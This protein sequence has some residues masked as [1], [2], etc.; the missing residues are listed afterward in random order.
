MVQEKFAFGVDYYPEHWPEERWNEDARLMAEAGFNVVRL[1]EFAWSRL[2]PEEGCF[3][4]DWLDRA[5]RVLAAQGLRVVLGTP[6]ASPPPWVMES[7]PG[8]Y[9]V[10]EDGQTVT[11]GNR[12]SYCPTHPRYRALAGRIVTAMANHYRNHPAVIAWQIDN[13][14][15]D[16]CYCAHCQDSFRHWLQKRY[17]SLD[18]LN[19]A[20]GTAFWSHTYTRWD[21]VPVPLLTGGSPNPGLALDFARFSSDSY[22]DFQSQQIQILRESCP[23]HFITH[24]FMGFGYEQLNYFDLAHDLDLVS[25]DNYP[26][27][28]WNGSMAEQVDPFSQALNHAAMRGLKRQ[29]FWVMEQQAGPAGWERIGPSPRPGEVRLWAYQSIAHGADGVL[30][31]RWRTSRFGTEQFWHGLL[32]HDGSASRRYQEVAR[33]GL[34]LKQVG[35]L[36]YG[37]MVK[38]PVAMLSS[39]DSR[40]AFQLQSTHPG[41]S[42]PEHFKSIYRAFSQTGLGVDVVAPDS[43]LTP[44]RLVVA[45]ALY[46]VPPVVAE[47]LKKYVQEGGDL[48]ITP[49]SGVKDEANAVFA[50]PLPGPL[51]ELAGVF[52]EEY[53]SLPE[54]F[55]PV[56]EF[57]EPQLGKFETGVWCDLLKP[58]TANVIARYSSG[59]LDGKVAVTENSSAGGRVIYSG[60]YGDSDFFSSLAGYLLQ[61]PEPPFGDGMNSG[62]EVAFRQQGSKRLA[63]LLNHAYTTLPVTIPEGFK[64]LLGPQS[65]PGPHQIPALDVWI[66]VEK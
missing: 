44:Y 30:F 12:R 43:D 62:L 37:S 20:W 59:W 42:Y 27:S 38:S 32:D 58:G 51:A 34:E 50:S 48:L 45:P 11:F 35:D 8:L 53:D 19:A 26:R 60:V 24:N 3:Q 52:V 1:A 55:R 54:D 7:A 4:F 22:V 36:I 49:R 16:R 40:F 61:P 28:Q 65:S 18:C 25:W 9:R 14:F 64:I 41:F 21:Q 15:G 33:L 31:F 13:E 63:F 57:I 47:N 46:V 29:N 56:V 23:R 39:Y 6:T 66:L 10:R 5:I 2:E 17:G